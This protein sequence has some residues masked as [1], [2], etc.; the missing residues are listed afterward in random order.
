MNAWICVD[1]KP[2]V[3]VRD[4]H[5]SDLLFG[6]LVAGFSEGCQL[7]E[8]RFKAE[9]WQS[10]V[11]E[12]RNWKC[13]LFQRFRREQE[14]KMKYDVY[15]KKKVKFQFQFC[16]NTE[17]TVLLLF[18]YYFWLIFLLIFILIWDSMFLMRYFSK[19][20]WC[21]CPHE[22]TSATR[23]SKGHDVRG[24]SAN[25]IRKKISWGIHNT[26]KSFTAMI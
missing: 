26:F 16:F 6:F 9:N 2:S 22:L 12:T 24:S 21:A 10:K 25:P 8:K 19:K 20:V 7:L 18:C 15:H 3:Y 1:F 5:C 14:N 11:F 23:T 13:V 4:V 17:V